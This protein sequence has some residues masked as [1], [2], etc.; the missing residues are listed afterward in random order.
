MSA[1]PHSVR[2]QVEAANAA[3]EKMNAPQEAPS[4]PSLEELAAQTPSEPQPAA[5]ADPKAE[6][7]PAEPTTQPVQPQ[8]TAENEPWEARYKTL[9]GLF[10]AQVPKLQQKNAE[11]TAKLEQML[12]EMQELKERVSAPKQTDSE[13]STNFDKDVENFGA[14]LVGMVQRVVQAQVVSLAQKVDGAVASY[15]RRIAALEQTLQGTTKVV[16]STAEEAFFA[17]LTGAV[18]DWEQINVDARFLAW[19]EQIDPVYG[20]PRQ[21]ALDNAQQ[22][23]D[24]GRAAAIFTAFKAT[25]PQAPKPDTLERQVTP[26]TQA[27]TPVMAPDKPILSQAQVAKFYDDRRRGAYRGREAEAAR[28]EAMI[29]LA[30]EEGR[31]R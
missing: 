21:A 27:A 12:T 7:P 6:T 11:L 17:K 16:A 22:S 1:L 18:P 24:A 10:N 14:D 31:I 5:P 29:N 26:T 4:A 2:K 28:I 3:I 30:I 23:L 13:P 25:L 9:Q 15:E 8:P 19:L 20:L